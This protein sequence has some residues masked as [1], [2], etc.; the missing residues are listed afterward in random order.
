MAILLLVLLVLMM[1]YA[2]SMKAYLQQQAH[3]AELNAQIDQQQQRIAGLQRE[4]KR[5]QDP[6]YLRMQA[7]ERFGYVEPGEQSF[8][9]VDANGDPID[10]E[11]SLG[12]PAQ[13]EEEPTAW[14]ESAWASVELAGNPPKD[15]D[16]QLRTIR[17]GS[18]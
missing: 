18:G 1:S 9:V 11:S 7:R 14:W 15:P 17:D 8:V 10:P 12:Q 5:W 2:S 13:T 3:I 4:K 16:P 6:A